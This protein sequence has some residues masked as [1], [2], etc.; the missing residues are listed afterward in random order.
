MH[1]FYLTRLN[2]KGPRPLR[3]YSLSTASNETYNLRC[4][5]HL[6][7]W[8]DLFYVTFRIRVTRC[9]MHIRENILRY[10]VVCFEVI[11]RW[12]QTLW[13]ATAQRKVVDRFSLWALANIFLSPWYAGQYMLHSVHV[14]QWMLGGFL[15]QL[16]IMTR[17]KCTTWCGKL[18]P[19]EV[20]TVPPSV[21]VL[22]LV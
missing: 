16:K 7:W 1:R 3:R 22:D 2:I 11:T 21:K 8:Y 15:P 9:T 6:A 14:D 12:C 18:P 10:K 4:K 20:E 19:C 5:N 13:V 17:V